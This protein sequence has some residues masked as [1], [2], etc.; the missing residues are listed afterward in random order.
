MSYSLIV[1]RLLQG[2]NLYYLLN[3]IIGLAVW[4]R[5]SLPLDLLS[6]KLS[7]FILSATKLF[8]SS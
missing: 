4:P 6:R 1:I 2:F 7:R 5:R 8:L 3:I